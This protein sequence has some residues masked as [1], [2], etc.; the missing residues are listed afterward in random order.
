MTRA[1]KYVATS[2]L[3]KAIIDAELSQVSKKVYI[4]RLRTMVREFDTNV[5]WIITHPEDVLKWIAKKSDVL[6]TQKSYI[7][8]VM[9]VFKHNEGL[10]AQQDKYYQIWFKKF[11]EIDEAITQRYKTNEPSERQ[12]NAYVAFRDIIKKRDSLENGT[13]DKLLLGFYS[14][15][16]PLR[17]DFNAVFL[18]GVGEGMGGVLPKNEKDREANYIVVESAT[19]AKLVL[20]EFK[21][22]RSHPDFNKELPVELVKELHASL[23]K[24][25]R[26]WLFVDKFGKP[27]KA[28]N[29]YTRWANRALLRLFG[30]PLTITLIRHSYISS[31][32]QNALTTLEKEEIAKEM[33]HSRGM[34]ELYRFVD[35]GGAGRGVGGDV[36]GG[37]GG[38]GDANVDEITKSLDVSEES[39]E[40]GEGD[41]KK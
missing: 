13:M 21:T 36:G 23:K 26:E 2:D 24:C 34:Q 35:K 8:S 25:P 10:K 3:L 40:G 16:R 28:A 11:T 29:S 30:K 22:Q 20:H 12:L 37:G 6:S 17:A 33:A 39:G 27:Y 41:E 19:K 31:L 1:K 15:I 32:D 14:H 5:Y 4:E 38:G 7:I 18:Y 9:A